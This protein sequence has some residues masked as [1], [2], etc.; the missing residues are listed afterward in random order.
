MNTLTC[1]LDYAKRGWPVLPLYGA[2]D[3]RCTCG[4]VDCGSP[5]K[6]P[7][8]TNGLKGASTDRATIEGW[9]AKWPAANI[10]ITTG[11][12][13]GLVVLDVDPRHGGNESLDELIAEHGP[14]PATVE[15][16][17]GGGGRHLYFLHPGG[18]IKNSAGKIGNGL[19]VKADGGYV[20]A[21][22]SVHVSGRDYAW[23][24]SSDPGETPLADPPAWLLALLS[25]GKTKPAAPVAGRIS[26]G[27]RNTSLARLAG[28]MRREGATEAGILAALRAENVARCDPPL[29]DSEVESIARS[30]GRYAPDTPAKDGAPVILPA[31]KSVRQ[32]MA[33]HPALRPPVIYG[34]LRRG[35]TMNIIAPPKTGKSWLVT[36]LALVVATGRRWLGEFQTEP[37]DVL[38]LD[39]ELHSE[40]ISH[41]IP[42]VA[43]VRGIPR[44]DFADRVFV[45]NLRGRLMDLYG[46]KKYLDAV[47]PDRFKVIVLDAW[48]RFLPRDTDE[49]DNGTLANLYNVLDALANRLGCCFVL[50]HHASKGSQS[51]KVVT[52]VGSGAGAQSRATDTHL[53]LRPHETDGVVVLDAAVRSWPPVS[54][55]CLRWEFPVWKPAPDLDPTA[56]KRESTRGRKAHPKEPAPPPQTWT[57]DTFTADFVTAEPLPQASIIE[58][59]KAVDLK[60]KRAKSLLQAAEGNGL[61]HRW[62]YGPR[63]PDR[64][65]TVP[66]PERPSKDAQT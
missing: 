52:D 56:L 34:L 32:L 12:A 25:N 55:R 24:V 27:T 50:I 42:Q 49:N 14:L 66:Q 19:D 5:A 28:S 31:F 2:R 10:G 20:V 38:I 33:D 21:P 30:I 26:A 17:T 59:A 16:L 22:P 63:K 65:A 23:E 54:A 35:E 1:A 45:D 44:Q 9:W 60:E 40:T 3:G 41:R 61:V 39:N 57:P 18:T 7:C 64:F 48:Y 11:A 37:G 15:C 47:E 51:G 46:V 43:E 58:A 53:V 36:D 6:H 13:S 29:A 4:K 8:T 62:E